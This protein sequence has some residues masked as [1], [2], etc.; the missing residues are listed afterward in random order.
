MLWRVEKGDVLVWTP[1]LFMARIN[2]FHTKHIEFILSSPISPIKTDIYMKPPKLPTE[3]EIPDLPNFTDHFIYVYKL[4][5]NLY[6][7]KDNIKT[8]CEYLKHVILKQVWRE[9]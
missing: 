5:N 3:F 7:L 4:I 1:S 9:L 8:W 2:N 6:G